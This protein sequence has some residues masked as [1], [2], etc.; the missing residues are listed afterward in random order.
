[1]PR[2]DVTDLVAKHAGE[3]G[4]GVEIHEQAA[5]HVDVAAAGGEGVDGLV[6]ED[7]ELEFLVGQIAALRDALADHVHVFLHG[8]VFVETVAP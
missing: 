1:M 8:L 2:G 6:V 7:E 5:I 3:L 4:F